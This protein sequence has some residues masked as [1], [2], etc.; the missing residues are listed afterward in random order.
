M[1]RASYTIEHGGYV[2]CADTIVRH[3]Q[4]TED[5][6]VEIIGPQVPHLFMISVYHRQGVTPSILF[7]DDSGTETRLRTS[8]FNARHA[9][10]LLNRAAKRTPQRVAAPV[11]VRSMPYWCPKCGGEALIN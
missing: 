6:T 9:A 10:Q 4:I 11:A 1:P 5:F 2:F 8:P 3:A 7:R